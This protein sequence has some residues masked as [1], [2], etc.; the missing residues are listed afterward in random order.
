MNIP[1]ITDIQAAALRI[2]PSIHHTPV[3]TSSALNAMCDAE[4]FFKCDNFQKAGAF[5]I[6]GATNTVLLLCEQDE[7]PTAVATHSSGNHAAAVALAAR[8]QGLAAY[9]V[10]PKNAPSIKQA[11]VADYGAEIIFCEP[12]L[13]ARETGLAEVVERTGAAFIHPYN[14]PRVIAGQGTA[15]LELFEDVSGLDMVLTPVGGGGLLCGTALTMAALSPDT[16][17]LAGEPQEADDAYRSLQAGKLIPVGQTKTIADGLRTSLGSLTFVIIQKH[18]REIL[19]VSEAEIVQAMRHIWERMKIIVEPS[20][21]VPF[22]ALLKN[23]E[24]FRGKRVGIILTGGNV[25]VEGLPFAN[26]RR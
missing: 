23:K 26:Y 13:E 16:Q 14:D 12:T 8:S 17:V 3:L 11:A 4:I 2:G 22:A 7:K 24:Q 25:D 21:A 20:S 10:M 15:A 19:T 5:K 9:V 1:T 18:V 6:R